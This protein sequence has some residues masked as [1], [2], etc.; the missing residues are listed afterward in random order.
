MKQRIN[1][2][3]ANKFKKSFDPLSFTGSLSI[4]G[5]TLTI[6]F[7]L[8]LGLSS[9]AG[10]QT[11]QIAALKATKKHL[12]AEVISQQGRFANQNPQKELL[13]EQ[14]RLKQEIS[15]RQQLKALLHQ[16]Q[17]SHGASFST[18]LLALAESS[19]SQSWLLQFQLDNEQQRFIATGL[20]LD[21]PTVPLTL[22]AIGRTETFQGMSVEQLNVTSTEQGVLF[23]VTAGLRSYE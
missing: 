9:Y 13:V 8:G 15:S 12:D 18:Y 7:V 1:L 6:F 14:E 19:L 11:D 2:Y 20:A 4:A 3:N 5:A 21:G 17:P 23:D 22:E 16:V 10:Y